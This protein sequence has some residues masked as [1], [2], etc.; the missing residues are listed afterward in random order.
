[1]E[2]GGAA[3]AILFGIVTIVQLLLSFLV[4]SY[5]GYSFLTVFI[6]TSAG[7]DE[8]LWPKDPFQDWMWK[9]WYLA[10]LLA[11]WAIPVWLVM[12]LLDPP[13]WQFALILAGFLWL[14]FPIGLL[15]SLSASSRWVVLRPVVVGMFVRNIGS[16]LA[17]YLI[18]GMLF[19]GWGV[20]LYYAVLGNFYFVPVAAFA[21]T[22]VFLIYAR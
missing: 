2:I 8:V 1:M 12:N 19:A 4:L 6:N 13:V 16:T 3:S 5:A 18:T 17:F 22:S 21:G 11:I 10:W 15:S 20:L 7:S 14:M 9:S